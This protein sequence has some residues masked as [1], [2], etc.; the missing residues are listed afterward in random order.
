MRSYFLK[1]AVPVGA[2]GLVMN[3]EAPS[4]A[5]CARHKQSATDTVTHKQGHTPLNAYKMT[6]TQLHTYSVT[7]KQYSV[8]QKQSGTDTVTHMPR[9]TDTATKRQSG[10]DSYTDTVTRGKNRDRDMRRRHK[11]S[12]KKVSDTELHGA[13]AALGI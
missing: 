10:A 7:Q 8:T 12:H 2:G 11:G 5:A 4:F 6:Q 13:T 1:P 9:S 3:R